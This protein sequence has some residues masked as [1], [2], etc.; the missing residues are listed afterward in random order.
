MVFMVVLVVFGE[1][2]FKPH[3]L[4]LGV[5]PGLGVEFLCEFCS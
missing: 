1:V 3:Y 4:A 5:V 2:F